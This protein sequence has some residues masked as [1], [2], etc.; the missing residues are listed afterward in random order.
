MPMWCTLVAPNCLNIYASLLFPLPILHMR[1]QVICSNGAEYCG[2][3]CSCC[4]VCRWREYGRE[5]SAL[6]ETFCFGQGMRVYVMMLEEHEWKW[7][8]FVAFGSIGWM[9]FYIFGG[10]FGCIC[11]L[12]AIFGSNGNGNDNDN[13]RLSVTKSV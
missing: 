12:R 10:T 7:M 13:K 5:G 9:I 6:Q 4:C 1:K 11:K 3:S 2:R 8:R